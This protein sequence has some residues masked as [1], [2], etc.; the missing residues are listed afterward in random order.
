MKQEHYSFTEIMTWLVLTAAKNVF[1]QMPTW[2]ILLEA[3]GLHGR[4]RC[5]E[6]PMFTIGFVNQSEAQKWELVDQKSF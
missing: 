2:M 3:Q 4:T 1:P 6:I 5:A